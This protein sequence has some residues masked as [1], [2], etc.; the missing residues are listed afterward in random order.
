MQAPPTISKFH[1][2]V[3]RT[4]LARFAPDGRLW[5]YDKR[6]GQVFSRSIDDAFGETHLNTLIMPDGTRDQS[7]EEA[8]AKLESRIKP[9]I[10]E[11]LA[12]ARAGLSPDVDGEKRS[13]WDE[14]FIAQ[15]ARTPDVFNAVPT[16]QL[17]DALIREFARR[18]KEKYPHRADEADALVA[19]GERKRLLKAARIQAQTAPS[20]RLLS[21][22]S[23]RSLAGLKPG[24]DG[25]QFLIG[26]NPFVRWGDDLRL[27][28]TRLWL[29]VAPDLALGPGSPGAGATLCSLDDPAEVDRFNLAIA[30]RSTVIASADRAMVEGLKAQVEA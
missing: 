17:G 27:P 5:V 24:G 10:D 2:Y 6:A 12:A 1:H 14:Y 21:L 19:D 30:R 3:A 9:V 13:S 26:S 11:M 22:L 7:L 8:L 4:H 16:L 25:R 28:D 15:H 20:R 29:P 23:A 18:A